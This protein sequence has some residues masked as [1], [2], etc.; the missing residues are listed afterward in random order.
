MDSEYF[1]LLKSWCDSLMSLQVTQFHQKELYGGIMCPSCGRIHG[2]CA[3]AIYPMMY[4][5]DAAGDKI[6]L[7]CAKK[8]FCWSDNLYWKEGYYYN[9]TNSSWRGITVF[10]C[11]QLGEALLRHGHLLD[12]ETREKWLERLEATACYLKD[13]M[14]EIGGNINYP[15]ACAHAMAV[16]SLVLGEETYSQKAGSLAR[17]ALPH[18]T[19]DGLLY[20]EG[21]SRHEV[22]PKGCRPVDLGYNVEESLPS[23][24]SY[25]V[26][27]GDKEA[28]KRTVLSMKRHLNFM[29]PDG[30][31]DNSWGTRNNKWTYW[32]S[33]TS[34]GCQSGYGLLAEEIPEF[35]EA[36]RRNTRL[37]RECTHDGLL[38]GGPMYASAGEP[39]C[40]HHTFCHAKALASLLDH[41]WKEK[42]ITT[43]KIPLPSDFRR[44]VEDYP[45]VHVKLAGIGPWR[46]TI[47]DY[48]V[49]YSEE[50]HATGGAVTLLWHQKLGPIFAGTMGRYELI[51]PNNMQL[52]RNSIPR[53]QTPRI[54]IEEQGVIYR[55]INDKQASADCREESETLCAAVSGTMRDG[56]QQGNILFKINYFFF[57]DSFVIEA[58]AEQ[59]AKL[60]LPFI[61]RPLVSGRNEKTT[62]RIVKRSGDGKMLELLRDSGCKLKILATDPLFAAEDWLFHPV[63]GMQ[64]AECVMELK[65]KTW[66]RILCMVEGEKEGDEDN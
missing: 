34:D 4:M 64:A 27:E 3:D 2:R 30:A 45:S 6:Y 16:A 10:F 21:K 1:D 63:G 56:K 66:S 61:A 43:G 52:P 28:E 13:H 7:E 33:R 38:Y 51:E 57:H 39:P 17:N 65:R 44:G 60:I 8:L 14:E 37:L 23:L 54:E 12:G 46:A 20:G 15:V 24:L 25:A 29:L 40:V 50:G 31:W 42:K 53:C 32:G 35:A 48:D 41:G 19:D 36:V 11:I 26:M 59:D 55:S 18:F 62:D 9:D 58:W 49:E 5:A 22:S 47:S